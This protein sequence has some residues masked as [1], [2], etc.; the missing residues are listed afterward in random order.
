M[1]EI[2]L[3]I[4]DLETGEEERVNV[5]SRRFSIGRLPENDLVIEDTSLSRR[6]ALIETVDG[7]VIVSDCGSQNGTFVN[8]KRV[9]G[10]VELHDGDVLTFGGS[11]EIAIEI[12]R[13]SAAVIG[14]AAPVASRNKSGSVPPWMNA[15]VLAVVAVVVILAGAGLLLALNQK[16]GSARSA[17]SPRPTIASQNSAVVTDPQ[18]A[19]ARTADTSPDN[20]VEAND[21]SNELRLIDKYAR[22]VMSSISDDRSPDRKSTR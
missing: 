21:N 18:V 10:A 12:S 15:P 20:N 8:G 11:K 13:E 2:A 5:D 14:A 6:H 22:S 9:V 17:A 1:Q 4:Y 19:P 7:S 3:T 16:N